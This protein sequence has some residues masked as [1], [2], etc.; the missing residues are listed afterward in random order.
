MADVG[1]KVS[2]P[3]GDF[4]LTVVGSFAQD[5]LRFGKSMATALQDATRSER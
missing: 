1:C 2:I 4:G 5:L 3:I